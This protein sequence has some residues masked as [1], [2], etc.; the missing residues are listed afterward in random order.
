M[1]FGSQDS[2]SEQGLAEIERNQAELRH[3]I[4]E[5]RRLAEDNQELLDRSAHAADD[6]P[7]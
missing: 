4:E 2:G 6:A 1:A 3:C 7:A 5:A